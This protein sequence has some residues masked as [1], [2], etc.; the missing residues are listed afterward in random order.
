M[1]ELILMVCEWVLEVVCLVY[2]MFGVECLLG[3]L[4]V[5]FYGL[6][7]DVFE[8]LNVVLIDVI[9]FDFVKGVILIGC[10]EKVF[11]GGVIDGYNIW[12][13]DFVV[14]FDMVEVLCEVL[15]MVLVGILMSLFYMLYM[16]VDEFEFLL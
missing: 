3:I 10:S 16:V 2:V 7:D 15:L 9:V 12:C 8:V 5:V 6:F 4:V 1:S 11:V 13:G 14:V